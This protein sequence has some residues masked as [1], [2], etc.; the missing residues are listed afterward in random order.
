MKN[1]YDF[2]DDDIKKH[3]I[4]I[5]EKIEKVF[6]SYLKNQS[7]TNEEMISVFLTTISMLICCFVE[8]NFSNCA[9]QE[10]ILLINNLFENL[11]NNLMKINSH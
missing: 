1:K 10:K 2:I 11:K 7:P 9:L 4:I 5:L 8:T 6:N 3:S